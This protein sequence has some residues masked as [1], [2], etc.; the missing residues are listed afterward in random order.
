MKA[1][2][3]PDFIRGIEQFNRGE[4]FEC[5][6]TLEAIWAETAGRE[7]RF[8]QGLI[9]I[10]VGFYHFENGNPSGALSQWS[11]GEEK[12]APFPSGTGGVNLSGLLHDLAEWK[13]AA[14]RHLREGTPGR[15]NIELPT[16]EIINK[17][18]TLWPQ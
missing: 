12:L 7:R 10:A 8:L 4:F 15:M 17:R 1:V 3:G 2:R 9:Q 6:D 18:R 14:V 13:E 5:H 11:R 16:I